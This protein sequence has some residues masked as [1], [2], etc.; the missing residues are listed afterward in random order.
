[1]NITPLVWPFHHK[2]G[3]ENYIILY[4]LDSNPSVNFYVSV[5][6][7]WLIK[8]QYPLQEVG[9]QAANNGS[10]GSLELISFRIHVWFLLFLS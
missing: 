2:N 10:V 8:T 3:I 9:S 1:M 6:Q 5:T 4:Q 7:I